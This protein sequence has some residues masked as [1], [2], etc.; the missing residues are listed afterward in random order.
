VSIL[1]SLYI[2]ASGMN[3]HGGAIGVVGDNIANVSTIGYKRSRA[4]FADVLGGSLGGRRLGSGVRLGGIDQQF[5]QGS[6]QQTGA[7]LDLA[8]RG[9]GMFV[10]RGAHEGQ[11]GTCFT[12]DGRF[13][14]DEHGFV[15]DGR[16]LRLQGYLID[17]AGATATSATDLDLA[18]AESPPVATTTANLSFHLDPSEPVVAWDPT[19]PAGTSSHQTTITVRDS[20]GNPRTV[21]LYFCKTADGAWDWHAM[22]DGGELQGGTAGTPTEI[23]SGALAFDGNG[24]LVS[25]T[26]GPS[27]ASF[28]GA[29]PN[30]AIAFD[31]GDAIADGGTGRSGTTQTAGAFGVNGLDIDGRAA[32]KLIDV[33]V[34]DDGTVRGMYDN[35]DSHDIARVALALFAAE[36]ELA[37]AG[38]GLYVESAAS[39]QPLVAAAGSGG[40]GAI[41]GG[42]LEGSNVDLGAELVTMIAYQRAFQANVKTVTTADE[43]LAEVAQIKR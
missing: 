2:G 33:Q 3:A 12:R 30:Q 21:D 41:S 18:S 37:R 40:R 8:I 25:E 27:S 29:T 34:G 38:D 28:L 11:D 10:V 15:V 43:M 32:G 5:D 14:L 31:F 39:G 6:L 16:G 13:G 20:L 4:D 35:G 22:V 23:A 9:E 42:A 1:N 36:A 24:A 19:D 17:G 7:A 26:P